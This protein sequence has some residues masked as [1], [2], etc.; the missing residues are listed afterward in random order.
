MAAGRRLQPRPAG[1]HAAPAVFQ[2]AVPPPLVDRL[3][4]AFA[5]TSAYWSESGYADASERKKYFTF[6]VDDLPAL[7]VE[8]GRAPSDAAEALVRRLAPLA[9]R[10]MDTLGGARTLQ[11]CEWWVHSRPAH[12]RC[13][14]HQLHYDLEVRAWCQA[15]KPRSHLMI[16][17]CTTI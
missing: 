3:A 9:Q 1:C 17:G 6:G 2:A 11:C 12:G 10:F 5:P 8:G 14:G 7:L 16:R 4:R 15:S 13:A